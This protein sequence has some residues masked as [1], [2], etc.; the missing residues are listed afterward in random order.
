MPARKARFA[1]IAEGRRLG[2]PSPA[3]RA[4]SVPDHAATHGPYQGAAERSVR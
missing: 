4:D 2:A 3:W 1:P